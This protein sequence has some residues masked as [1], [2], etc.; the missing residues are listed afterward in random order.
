MKKLILTSILSLMAFLA[1]ANEFE[2][3][4]K[5]TDISGKWQGMRYQFDQ[6]R[7]EYVTEFT[8]EYHLTQNGNKIEGTSII[9]SPSGNFAEI[10]L[11]GFVEGDKFYF[12]EFETIAAKRSENMV[13]CFKK[14]VLDIVKEDNKI[15]LKGITDSYDEIYGFPCTGGYSYLSKD[16]EK[17]TQEALSDYYTPTQAE[18]ALKFTAYPNPFQVNTNLSFHLSEASHVVVD[19]VSAN[20]DLVGQIANG[21][22]EKGDYVIDFTPRT[23]VRASS[24]IVRLN[25]NGKVYTKTI[26]KA[27]F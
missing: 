13:W 3:K 11:K 25:V 26:Q 7:K 20:G 16:I 24:F 8:Y 1:F 5:S 21:D 27:N 23:H 19:V 22:Y 12:E 17:P 18:E 15:I 2:V 10:K 4:V 6:A 14:G 9:K